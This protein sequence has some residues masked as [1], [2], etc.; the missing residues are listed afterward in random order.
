MKK[1][2][3]VMRNEKEIEQLKQLLNSER[4]LALMWEEQGQYGTIHHDRIKVYSK[5][6]AKLEAKA[7]KGQGSDINGTSK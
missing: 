7:D 1:S 3:S 5:S 2:T 4:A 6:L